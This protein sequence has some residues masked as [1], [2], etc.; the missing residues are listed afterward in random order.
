MNLDDIRKAKEFLSPADVAKIFETT[1]R[2]IYRWI[3][4]G[5][6]PPLQRVAARRGW[7]APY[8]WEYLKKTGSGWD[9][10]EDKNMMSF[11]KPVT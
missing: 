1:P 5:R 10:R 3:N 7:E 6:L 9:K 8:L 11:A 4:E 2:T